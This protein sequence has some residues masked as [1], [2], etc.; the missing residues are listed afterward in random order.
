MIKIPRFPD[1]RARRCVVCDKIP[2][3]VLWHQEGSFIFCTRECYEW[4]LRAKMAGRFPL[5]LWLCI[6]EEDVAI[7]HPN[8]IYATKDLR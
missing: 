1:G 3:N 8:S 5:T 4:C 7:Y 2:K 6:R